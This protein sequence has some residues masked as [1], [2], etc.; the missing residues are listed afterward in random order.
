MDLGVRHSEDDLLKFEV[1]VRMWKKCGLSNFECGMI[2]GIGRAGLSVSDTAELLRLTHHNNEFT[3]LIC[4]LHSLDLDPVTQL[5]HVVE[6]EILIVYFLAMWCYQVVVDKIP[7]KCF[8][9]LIE[10]VL[11]RSWRQIV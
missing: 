10:S 8:H 2:A 11:R 7:E 3:A 9:N 1:S 5:W 6:R 4:P